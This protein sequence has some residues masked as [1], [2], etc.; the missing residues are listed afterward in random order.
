MADS[1]GSVRLSIT[2]PSELKEQMDSVQESVNWSGVAAEAFR[3][4]I[5][6]LNSQ[7]QGASMQDVIAR[8]KA[9]R[10]MEENE[11]RE[12]GVES[13]MNWAKTQATPKQLT[14]LHD[15]FVKGGLF[16]GEPDAFGWAGALYFAISGRR[17]GDRDTCI[18]FWKEILGEHHRDEIH[19][20]DF[21][22]GF[23]VGALKIW[24][25][26]ADKL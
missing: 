15:C 20:R 1:R 12:E 10:E 3:S 6:D 19:D 5:L 16:Q 23:V 26:V 17:D 9:A 18:H 14:R 4:K 11:T 7:R 21:A 22:E 13:G 25:I 24:D 2:V 8:L